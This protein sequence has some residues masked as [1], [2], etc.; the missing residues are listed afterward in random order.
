MAYPFNTAFSAFLQRLF[1]VSAFSV[2][3]LNFFGKNAHLTLTFLI[4]SLLPFFITLL[5][6]NVCRT[7]ADHFSL[8]VLQHFN[9]PFALSFACFCFCFHIVACL[10]IAH[11]YR[12]V[13]FCKRFIQSNVN[14]G[15]SYQYEICFL[16]IFSQK[17]SLI[18]F[19]NDHSLVVSVNRQLNV[20]QL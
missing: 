7:F 17:I 5:V 6:C 3:S 14:Q 13:K 9:H 10:Q 11:T 2:F 4:N 16:L 18:I 1:A 12:A 8:T 20:Y 19:F 15:N